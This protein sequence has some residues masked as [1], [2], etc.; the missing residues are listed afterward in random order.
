MMQRVEHISLGLSTTAPDAAACADGRLS[1]DTRDEDPEVLQVLLR[2][3]ALCRGNQQGD[4]LVVAAPEVRDAAFAAVRRSLGGPRAAYVPQY[5]GIPERDTGSSLEEDGECGPHWQ[6][7]AGGVRGLAVLEAQSLLSSKTRPGAAHVP[8]STSGPGGCRPKR[9]FEEPAE[10]AVAPPPQPAQPPV[11]EAARPVLEDVAAATAAALKAAPAAV[12]SSTLFAPAA[13]VPAAAVLPKPGADV[14]SVSVPGDRRS[15][16]SDED[17]TT[18]FSIWQVRLLLAFG[19]W[20]D[21]CFVQLP[22]QYRCG[23]V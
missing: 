8:A 15:F 22:G 2:N 5:R 23:P 14:A 21:A 6:G 1:F 10:A 16:G 9:S 17:T 11:V 7:G 13:V 18:G 20:F 4:P 3:M 19:G 12:Q